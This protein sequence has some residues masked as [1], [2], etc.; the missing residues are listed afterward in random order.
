MGSRFLV[1]GL[2]LANISFSERR[3]GQSWRMGQILPH[4]LTTRFPSPPL[5]NDAEG[6]VELLKRTEYSAQSKDGS[7]R[8][9]SAINTGKR[10]VE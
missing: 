3:S 7:M 6:C 2:L 8:F 1:V 5:V 10:V 9:R 4:A